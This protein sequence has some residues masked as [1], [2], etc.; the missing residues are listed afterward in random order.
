[1]LSKVIVSVSMVMVATS[2]VASIKANKVDIDE[3]FAHVDEGMSEQV[4][5]AVTKKDS[6]EAVNLMFRELSDA[7]SRNGVSLH[8]EFAKEFQ[9]A[10]TAD[11][12]DSTD[13]GGYLPS[14]ACH[15]NC[16]ANCH[17]SR[18]WR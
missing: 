18:G 13:I 11:T 2:A 3:V 16:H 10:T 8:D 7:M 1:M 12:R 5:A 15:A 9:V 4:K 6:L 14:Y 17:A